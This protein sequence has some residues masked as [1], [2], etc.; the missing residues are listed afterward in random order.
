MR[1][2]W[3]FTAFCL[4]I[5]GGV[6]ALNYDWQSE[7]TDLPSFEKEWSFS[8]DEL[9]SLR[10]KSDY[11][12]KLTF[13]KS[14]DG[15]NTVFLKGQGT[16]KMIEETNAAVIANGTLQL[17]LVRKPKKFINF[18]DF[19]FTSTQEEIVVSL[20][21][22][23][24]LDALSMKLDSGN[25]DLIDAA[26]VPIKEVELSSDSGNVTLNNFK[27]D[28][29]SLKVDSG[30][31]KSDR[32]ETAL[33]A[34]VDTGN[35]TLENVVGAAD[36]SVD[37]GNVKLYKQDFAIVEIAN[38]VGNVFVQVPSGFTG[39]YDL[40]T[41]TGRVKSPESLRQTSDYI[42]V[43]TDTGNITVEEAAP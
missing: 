37:S 36:I 17:D 24:T 35:I 26:L 42:K 11:N 13:A 9:R 38:D 18:F 41:D 1:T 39:F 5:I 28:T 21:D 12:V 34:S 30:N 32:I 2:F 43:R 33:T 31:I 3:Y 15:R 40:K 8:A 23:A 27:S 14:P 7:K 20:A 10:I 25:L 16:E 29:L 4:I 19:N 22:G 6:G